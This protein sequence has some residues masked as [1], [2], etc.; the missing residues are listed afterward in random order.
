V[1]VKKNR[2]RSVLL[3]ISIFILWA[4]LL[5]LAQFQI[6][7]LLC[8]IIFVVAFASNRV[9][10]FNLLPVLLC[11]LAILC[12]CVL[13]LWIS[14]KFH[15]WDMQAKVGLT[16]STAVIGILSLVIPT[17]CGLEFQRISKFLGRK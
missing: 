15:S 9:F 3:A 12:V 10:A 11:Y 2:F 16:I 14:S 17:I 8:G 1:S 13:F 7:L 5:Y 6:S 4:V